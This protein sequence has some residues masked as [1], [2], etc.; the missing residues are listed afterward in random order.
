MDG[1]SDNSDPDAAIIQ[2]R[3]EGGFAPVEVVLG[4]GPTYTILGDGRIILQ[5]PIPEIYPGPLLPNYQV[6]RLSEEDMGSIMDYVAEMGLPGITEEA[7]DSATQYVADAITEVVTFWDS[8]GPHVY[9]VYALGIEPNPSNPK[10]AAFAK[11][12]DFISRKAIEIETSPYEPDTVQVIAGASMLLPDPQFEDVRPWPLE[13]DL[14]QWAELPNGW[15]CSTQGPDVLTLFED[16]TQLT[17]WLHP[18]PMMDAPPF[19]LLVRPL[20]PGEDS[21]PS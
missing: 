1:F 9:S 15:L 10:T 17:E 6:G 8:N 18:N 16:A 11:M 20:L 14:D 13:D 21:C 5:G 7:D 19:V 12:L 3:S 4:R 2:I